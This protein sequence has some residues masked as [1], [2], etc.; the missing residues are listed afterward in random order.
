MFTEV[1]KI[2]IILLSF[3]HFFYANSN[4]A[5]KINDFSTQKTLKITFEQGAIS[6]TS[7]KEIFRYVGLYN[8]HILNINIYFQNKTH[9]TVLINII[10]QL[11]INCD[12]NSYITNKQTYIEF[13]L[14]NDYNK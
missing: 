2:I 12:I 7:I 13:T 8:E 6:N 5:T 10:K 3:I 9:N 11:N 14:H 1:N 4:D